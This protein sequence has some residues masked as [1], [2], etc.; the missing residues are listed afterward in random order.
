MGKD[1]RG[2]RRVRQRSPDVTAIVKALRRIVRAIELYSQDV[3]REYHLTGPQL[4]A[5]KTLR[6]EGSLTPNQ[7]AVGLAVH[8]SSVSSLLRRLERRGLVQRRRVAEDRRSVRIHLTPRGA[9]L[10]AHA[11][12]PAQGR[13]LH[14]LNEMS[15][16]RLRSLRQAVESLVSTMEATNLKARFFFSD[17]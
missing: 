8:Q 7:L 2:E 10:A 1:T 12:E 3:K 4:W 14:G 11:P 16:R 13:L 6:R 9:T 15:P 5:L 17:D